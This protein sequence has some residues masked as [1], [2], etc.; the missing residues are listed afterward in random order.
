M[1]LTDMHLPGGAE[2]FTC[3]CW[4]LRCQRLEAGCGL[5][6]QV[7]FQRCPQQYKLPS[8]I[9][10]PLNLERVATQEGKRHTLGDQ[11]C[12][13]RSL[14]SLRL[15]CCGD[16]QAS[17]EEACRCPSWQL[18]SASPPSPGI[19]HVSGSF[20][21]APALWSSQQ[22]P[23]DTS[24]RGNLPIVPVSQCGPTESMNVMKWL[25]FYAP[26][27]MAIVSTTVL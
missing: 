3:H 18:Q 9:P 5:Q 8:H 25:L 13:V 15:P 4:N 19:R 22:R 2:F 1:L 6:W 24:R 20:R 11:N 17:G 21:S 26:K 14:A 12:H 10:L 7:V 23:P 16:V 27:F